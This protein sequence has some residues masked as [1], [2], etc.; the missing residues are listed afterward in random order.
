LSSLNA[1]NNG[2]KPKVA[3]GESGRK[4]RSRGG[5]LGRMKMVMMSKNARGKIFQRAEVVKSA[6]RATDVNISRS[7]VGLSLGKEW[8][9][10]K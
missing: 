3:E 7:N 5:Y 2:A 8:G 6:V 1:G 9:R 10:Q 4:I